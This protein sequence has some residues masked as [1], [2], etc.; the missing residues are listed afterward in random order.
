MSWVDLAIVVV[1]AVATLGGVAQGFLRS[2]CSLLGLVLGLALAA[3]NYGRVAAMIKPILPVPAVD[4]VIG[5]LVIALLVMALA[6]LAGGIMAKTIRWMGLGCLDK[7]GGAILGFLQGG[8]L[9][10][11][12]ILVTVAFFPEQHWLADARLPQM[13]FGACHLSA[14]MSPEELGD[15]VRSGLKTMEHESPKWMHPGNGGS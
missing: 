11:V 8:L 4:N 15:K 5:F 1:L 2:A 9:V 14:H 6:N 13:F 10:M 12:C 7:V 3:W